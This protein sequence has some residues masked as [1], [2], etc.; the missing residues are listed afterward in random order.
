MFDNWR[1]SLEMFYLNSPFTNSKSH[2]FDDH[3]FYTVHEQNLFMYC[4]WK[5]FVGFW[6][7][8]QSAS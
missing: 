1:I 4:L 3:Q 6:A 2:S 7:M 5:E 8:Q